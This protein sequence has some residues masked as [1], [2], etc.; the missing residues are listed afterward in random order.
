MSL[1]LPQASFSIRQSYF[2]DI[3]YTENNLKTERDKTM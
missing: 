3:G 2:S 1:V